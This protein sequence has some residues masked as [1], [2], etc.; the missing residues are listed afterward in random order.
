MRFYPTPSF[1]L[2]PFHIYFN[3]QVFFPLGLDNSPFSCLVFGRN[4][5]D[6][7]TSPNFVESCR[8]ASISGSQTA[9]YLLPLWSSHLEYRKQLIMKLCNLVAFTFVFNEIHLMLTFKRSIITSTFL[10]CS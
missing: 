3:L 10:R 7:H 1:C 9:S 2:K 5:T 8:A 6:V 4:C